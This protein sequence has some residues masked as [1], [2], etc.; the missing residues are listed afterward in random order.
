MTNLHFDFD[1]ADYFMVFVGTVFALFGV[2][3][4]IVL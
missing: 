2:V 4:L 1:A 3:A